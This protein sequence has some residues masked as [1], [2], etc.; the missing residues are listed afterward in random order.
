MSQ[1]QYEGGRKAPQFIG[2]LNKV[3][4]YKTFLNKASAMTDRQYL[5]VIIG[6]YI[7]I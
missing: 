6:I 1:D 5:Y 4:L 2:V 7:G 3:Y